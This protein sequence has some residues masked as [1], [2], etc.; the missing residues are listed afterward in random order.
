MG[1]G[2]WGRGSFGQTFWLRLVLPRL[3]LLA[4]LRG[5]NETLQLP[6]WLAVCIIGADGLIL[7]WQLWRYHRRA[8]QH[9]RETGAMALS[10]G[11]YLLWLLLTL[12]CVMLWWEMILLAT[13]AP[14]AETFE[15]QMRRERAARYVLEPD[16]S[17]ERLRFEGEITYGLTARLQALLATLPELREIE[18]TSPGG[19]VY[20]A[21]GAA[22][23]IAAAGL[24]TVASGECTSACTLLFIAGSRRRLAPGARLGFHGYGLAHAV[25]LPSYDIAAAEARDMDYVLSR[26]ISR[27]FAT[28]MFATPPRSMWYPDEAT[29]RAAAV[30]RD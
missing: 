17:G 11:G 13:R 2:N 3:L 8:E 22:Q 9:I 5:L 18:L 12:A 16:A 19:H 26:G 24:E 21:R 6:V 20:E 7:L 4:T 25:H 10:W 23:A 28:R 30:L 14:A 1:W 15:T 29:L 27:A